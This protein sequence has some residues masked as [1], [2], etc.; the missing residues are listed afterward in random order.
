[1]TKKKITFTEKDKE[2]LYRKAFNDAREDFEETRVNDIE[3]KS[4]E[5]AKEMLNK[6]LS[7]VDPNAI[8]SID[9][10][11]GMVFLGGVKADDMTLNNLKAEADFIT[12]SHIWKLMYE[13]PKELAQRFMFVSA[14]TLDDLRNGKSMLYTLNT[15]KNILDLCKSFSKKK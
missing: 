2:A 8:L 13:T 5:L 14:E 12:S 10:K 3:E 9:K 15:Q 11:N 1:M 7:V 6:M 4:L